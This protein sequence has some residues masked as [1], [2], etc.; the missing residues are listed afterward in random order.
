M[1]SYNQHIECQELIV[2]LLSGSI[3]EQE[4][5][6]L[7]N[8]RK[9]NP[10]NNKLFEEYEKTWE[11][12][13]INKDIAEIDIDAEWN[14]LKSNI[15]ENV[16]SLSPKQ[17]K[18]ISSLQYFIRI[19]AV[20]I[21]LAVSI[22][23]VYYFFNQGSQKDY[24]SV[25]GP[26]EVSL[27]DGSEISLNHNTEFKYPEKFAKD[28]RLVILEN[29]EAYFDVA[30]NKE[31]PFIINT[32]EIVIEVIGTS[33]NVSALPE[34][35]EIVVIVNSGKVAVYRKSNENDKII[36]QAGEKGTFIKEEKILEKTEN[37]DEN[38]KSW[39]TKKLVFKNKKLKSI[40]KTINKIYQS[41][42]IIND[43][44]KDCRYT[45]TFDNLSL[46][47]ILT[48]LQSTFDLKIDKKE[49]A[50]EISGKAC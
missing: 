8:W 13:N 19:A 37:V 35:N 9:Q 23:S 30:H 50:I 11:I 31:K 5:I 1:K 28:K 49:N 45:S 17:N 10:K 47:A 29:G 15:A 34:S 6:S 14:I 39:K 21:I 42:I 32:G 40:V 4:R 26:N 43:E 44:I 46:D 2:K 33:F 7:N 41:N 22:T 3:S 20:F 36:L 27:S 18:K 38:Y 24:L 12:S 48:I 25:N 16:V